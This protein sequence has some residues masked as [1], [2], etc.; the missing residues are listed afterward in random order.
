MK[1]I[2]GLSPAGYATALR[3]ELK[4]TGRI[5]P[6]EI[7]KEIGVPVYIEDLDKID[8]CLLKKAEAK[9]ILINKNILHLNRQ[10]FTLA[11]ELGHLRIKSHDE[12]MFRCWASDIQRYQG[13]KQIENEA[14][15][16]A[17]E[18]LLPEADIQSIVRKR[19]LSMGLVKDISEDYG[20]SLT[21]TALKIIKVCPDRGAV[22]LSENGQIKWSYSSNS[23]GYE[24]RK[25]KLHEFTYAYDY[26]NEG[27]LPDSPQRVLAYAWLGNARDR[28]QTLLEESIAIYSLGMVITLIYTEDSE[29]IE[30]EE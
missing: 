14:N 12:E 15:D 22:V 7:A 8:G 21:A 17:S 27:S 19:K 25:T 16:F 4:L 24:V 18:L 23:F 20:I 13:V 5:D 2:P 30:D 11:H 29:D 3:K 6:F 26:F 9:K 10:R 1:F 28:N